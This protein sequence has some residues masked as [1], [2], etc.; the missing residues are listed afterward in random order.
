MNLILHIGAG[1]TGSTSIQNVL[2][3]NEDRLTKQGFKYLGLMLENAD[4]LKYSWQKKTTVNAD[5]YSMSKNDACSQAYN[6]L[7]ESFDNAEKKGI[8]T[9]IWSN[10]SFF[11]H[12][13]YL[14]PIIN[15][16]KAAG[17]NVKI[18]AY[19]RNHESWLKSA[20]IQWGIKHK[21]YKGKL[22]S[23]SEWSKNNIPSFSKKLDVYWLNFAD[24]LVLKNLDA[25]ANGGDV[26]KDFLSVAAIKSDEIHSMKTNMAPVNEELL[27][28]ALFN[29]THH[30]PV[31]P[32]RFDNRFEF[33]KPDFNS[34]EDYLKN[35]LP[36]LEDFESLQKEINKDREQLNSYFLKKGQQQMEP[37]LIK[38]TD[39]QIDKDRLIMLLAQLVVGQ[40]RRVD[41]LEVRIA[42]LEG[43]Q[44]E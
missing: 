27:L 40:S 1:K 10:E 18:V 20:Y 7:I 14:I 23:F 3:N 32:Q 38:V 9:L 35:L 33:F 24:D 37:G 17:I 34:P 39:V 5:F 31:L 41:K 30:N 25:I 43:I 11:D 28:R 36:T 44:S 22:Q 29:A 8:H 42:K 19:V 16:I 6:I 26:V 4:T 21:T 2:L 13:D 12:S 15:R